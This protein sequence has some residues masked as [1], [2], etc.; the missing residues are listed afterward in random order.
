MD[1]NGEKGIKESASYDGE[2]NEDTNLAITANAVE[3]VLFQLSDDRINES[4]KILYSK[5]EVELPV[6]SISDSELRF[7]Y[8]TC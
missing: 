3:G 6:E 4:I 5:S 2:N 8:T 1:C 7:F